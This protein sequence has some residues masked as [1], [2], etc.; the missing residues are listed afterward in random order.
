MRYH[1]EC[2]IENISNIK[3]HNSIWA[4]YES[5]IVTKV[6]GL[7]QWITQLRTQDRVVGYWCKVN[8]DVCCS[9]LFQTV[10]YCTAA[11][12]RLD[13]VHCYMSSCVQLGAQLITLSSS[14]S[15]SSS[16]SR[17]S[18]TLHDNVYVSFLLRLHQK[19]GETP[20]HFA[21]LQ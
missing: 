2:C 21:T 10:L 20:A 6:N 14:S 12:T 5:G 8:T 13:V 3:S 16:S 17:L 18:L 7:H 11:A 19:L 9:L 1:Q 15:S 4:S